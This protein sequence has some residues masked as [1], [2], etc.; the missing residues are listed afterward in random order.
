MLAEPWLAGRKVLLLQ[1]RR[2]AVRGVAARLA[3]QLGQNVGETVG[4]RVRFESRVSGATQLEVMT[5]GILTRRLGRDPE[6]SDVGL[7]ILDEF[8]ERSLN[9]DLALALLREVQGALRDDL[10]VLIMS[11]TLDADLP[12][13]LG[14]PLVRSEGRTYPVEVRYAQA[15]PGGRIGDTV[16]GAVRRA[17]AEESGDVLAFLPGVAEI[18]QAQAALSEVDAVVLP[19]YGE[20][21]P[22]EQARA[23]TPDPQGQ[24]R[25]I[26][27]TSIAETSLTIEGVRVVVDSGQRRSQAYDPSTGL[28]GLRTGRVTR[29]EAEQRAGRAGRTAPGV[30]YRLWPERTQAL[31]AADRP[32]EMLGA[33]LGPLRLEL[34]AW[35]VTDPGSMEWLDAPPS[36][37]WS[38][39]GE[40]LRG[41]DAL[42]SG[43]RVTEA[44]EALLR[45]PTHPRLAHLLAE[46]RTG[47]AAD[48]AALLE[49]RGPRL[50]G[51]DLTERVAAL[52][53]ARGSG[54]LGEWAGAERLARQWRRLLDVPQDDAQPDAEHVG[55]LVALAY[56][57]RVALLR[58]GERGRYL[59][60]G[61]QGAEL[62]PDDPL[63]GQS[64]LAVAHLD[65]VAEGRRGPEGRIFLAAPLARQELEAR[66]T[67]QPRTDWDSR[68]GR[69]LAQE[70]WRVGALVLDTRPLR[71]P[72]PHAAAAAVAR[73]VT[74]EG[75]HLLTF[76]PA[77]Q[78]LRDRV[79]S[80]RTWR[81]DEGWPNL[82]DAALLRSTDIWLA[83][84]L[85]GIRS[86]E[87]LARLDLL[88]A[89]QA[90]LPWPL[91]SQLDDLAPTHLTVPSGNR[92]RLD[93]APDGSP[94][95]WQSRCRSC[96]ASMTR[97]R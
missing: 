21:P 22:T 24:R 65:G 4:S 80:L 63:S 39:A 86:R 12:A 32:P 89:L 55:W 76:S 54:R 2:V 1:P 72:D 79:N 46:G 84:F 92:I 5:E 8:H 53:Q 23:V 33:D 11:A 62:S 13:R 29:A 14:A 67:W 88:P 90:Q 44:G 56:P 16:A 17:L 36:P 83:P 75:L 27:A 81:P 68:T 18:R 94:R 10:R 71:E 20:L 91:A 87:A 15:E 6:L 78:S 69:L 47:L 42:D 93:Y 31:L 50:D 30:V 49:E 28:T 34:A 60:A 64:A 57:E 40:V 41:L 66:A 38:A 97:R 19:L 26:L 3:A 51:A 7:V 61:G 77:A 25:V 9:A 74:R 96:S 52:R 43:G 45:F 82:S 95:C 35:G 37:A 58:P 85:A 73:A 48:V 70:E 59:L